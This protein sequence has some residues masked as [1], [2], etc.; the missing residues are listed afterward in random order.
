MENM[1]KYPMTKEEYDR[2]Q[3]ESLLSKGINLDRLSMPPEELSDLRD[4]ESDNASQEALKRPIGLD[5]GLQAQANL[6]PEM[7]QNQLER[8]RRAN[9]AA[10]MEKYANL[11][12]KLSQ[13]GAAGIGA[14]NGK[15]SLTSGS[16]APS[17]LDVTGVAS[18]PM[19]ESAARGQENIDRVRKAQQA[20]EQLKMT[21]EDRE[22]KKRMDAQAYAKGEQSLYAGEQQ[23][24]RGET[25]M[26]QSQIKFD[27][28]Q[29]DFNNKEKQL[30]P[31]SSVSQIARKVFK[32]TYK[33]D[34]P[35][36]AS[37][38]DLESLRPEFKETMDNRL[39]LTK[40]NMDAQEAQKKALAGANQDTQK[41]TLD[42]FNT[43]K[44]DPEVKD[45]INA[46]MSF[47]RF[48][49]L[50][51]TSAGDI[52]R[53]F[54]FM[55]SFDPSSVV[56]ESEFALGQTVGSVLQNWLSKV[57]KITGEGQLTPTQRTEMFSALKGIQKAVER[58]LA[59][60]DE[61]Y[62]Q[63]YEAF[64]VPEDT[65]KPFLV[66]TS[67]FAKSS[68]VAD[69]KSGKVLMTFPDGSKRAVAPENVEAAKKA[70]AK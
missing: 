23:L 64:G 28:L 67:G 26:Q 33:Q 3:R 9:E 4:V 59:A 2:L 53:V 37:F 46:S 31:N 15:G 12:G 69:S 13:L 42:V 62:R 57:D 40:M 39:K 17:G 34:I 25:E 65:Y 60:K 30:D 50:D 35:D 47:S 49:A 8:E 16:L 68:D 24:K 10:R 5:E 48:K 29:R 6:T 70:G 43:Y 36:S 66:T 18:E 20:L 14:L 45:L 54:A 21:R 41:A 51:E 58:R 52:G 44:S 11:A 22:N 56:R 61:Q 7:M 55:K 27:M 38:A 1:G 32:D 19:K 63:R